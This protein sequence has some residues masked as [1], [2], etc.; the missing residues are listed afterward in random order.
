[1]RKLICL[2]V[3]MLVVILLNTCY[4][5]LAN[6]RKNEGRNSIV[7][8]TSKN[9]RPAPPLLDL[10]TTRHFPKYNK[11][12]WHKTAEYIYNHILVSTG[13]YPKLEDTPLKAKIFDKIEREDYTIEKVYFESYPG[14]FCTGNLYR[15]K[16]KAAPFPAIVSP[17]GHW[18]RGRLENT[19]LG[20]IPGRCINFAKQ[21][22]VIF[23]YDMVGYNDSG[24][25]I[26]HG[27]F[28]IGTR[29]EIWGISLMG[30]QLQ[31]GIRAV[32]FLQSLPDVDPERI[33]CTGASGGGTQT[34]MLMAVDQRIQVAAPVN[35]ISAHMQGGCL[36]ENSPNLRV[37]FSNMEIGAM[38]APRPLLL[39]SAT[40]DWT[41]NTPDVEYPAILSIYQHFEAT[42][43]VHQVQIDA[44]H[45]YNKASRE[46][47]YEWFGQWFLDELDPAKLKE[48]RFEVEQDEDLLIFQ[49]WSVPHHA[50]SM[51]QLIESLI[52]RAKFGIESRK[53]TNASE[54]KSYQA[55]M[56]KGLYHALSLQASH[57]SSEDLIKELSNP[58][59]AKEATLIVHQQGDLKTLTDQLSNIGHSIFALQLQPTD[60]KM[61]DRFFTTYNRTDQ[62]LWTQDILLALDRIGERLPQAKQNL[63]GINGGGVFAMLAAG[64]S[65]VDRVV[66]DA[67][68]FNT[69]TDDFFAEQLPI[70]S[71]RRVG[72]FRTAGALIAPRPMLIF[73]AGSQFPTTWI[74]N[75][76]QAVEK[77][78]L[79]SISENP[80]VHIAD[81]FSS[82]Q[83]LHK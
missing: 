19:E 61:D 25:Q 16:G 24:K 47:V 57:D 29:G 27:S 37:D 18:G 10:D 41:K 46:A 68:Q 43:K 56:G 34:F 40:G 60:R 49:H 20:S 50:L 31:N 38:M 3:L 12:N 64:F 71:I 35:M 9:S 48:G 11:E 5:G 53:P 28:N 82:T 69:E 83:L 26:D 67:E 30:L 52:Q 32:D 78:D 65:E 14:F 51:G 17:H 13:Q 77:P 72:D 21:G 59:N 1:M 54:L 45:N 74:S 23:S 15:P 73:N 44:D 8:E 62:A 75:I 63:V 22:Y 2:S 80:K 76:Y 58:T 36:C 4:A 7:E 42:D 55:E 6:S 33:G 70:P 81:W 79:L 66:I 39:V